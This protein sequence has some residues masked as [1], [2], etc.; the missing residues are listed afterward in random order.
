MRAWIT[1]V[2]YT[3]IQ[4]KHRGQKRIAVSFEKNTELIARFK[5]LKGAQWSATLK[6]WHLPDTAVYRERFG[7]VSAVAVSQEVLQ[8][9]DAVNQ[10]AMQRLVETLQLK[11]YSEYTIKTYRNEF[12][13]L[14]YL[15]KNKPVDTLCAEKIR[16][17]FLYCINVLKM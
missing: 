1:I 13:Q 4:I 3:A 7:I 8:K 6:T 15:L 5:K 11:G 9:I 17:Y 16:G 2:M 14:L 12:A 10:P